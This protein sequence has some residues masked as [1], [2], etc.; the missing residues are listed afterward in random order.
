EDAVRR[1]LARRRAGSG[2]GLR[3]RFLRGV[4]FGIVWTKRIGD[5]SRQEPRLAAVGSKDN[6]SLPRRS[7]DR[8]PNIRRPAAAVRERFVRRRVVRPEL[9]LFARC[10][11]RL[12]RNASRRAAGRNGGRA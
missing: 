7:T 3:G 9:V 4:A 5:R 6:R 11:R 8:P 12:G 1:L 2:P 10:E